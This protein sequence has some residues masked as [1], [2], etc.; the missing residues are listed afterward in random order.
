M[1][2][3]VLAGDVRSDVVDAVAD[4]TRWRLLGVLAAATEGL[5]TADLAAEVGLHPN[6]VRSHLD[7]LCA[8]GAVQVEVSAPQGRGRPTN[9]YSL[10]TPTALGA[11]AVS[12]GQHSAGFDHHVDRDGTNFVLRFGECPLPA[13]DTN[14]PENPACR[15][16][17]ALLSSQ[18]AATG[19]I[20]LSV[21]A[22]HGS[23]QAVLCPPSSLQEVSQ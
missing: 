11:A 6:T 23:C 17:Q 19:C 16:H 7:V 12:A 5:A 3:A 4:P 18:C 9:R 21:L 15:V 2:R 10:I 20:E 1:L 22:T 14:T 13:G 8:V